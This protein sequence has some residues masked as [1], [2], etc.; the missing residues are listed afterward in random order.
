M[1]DV[2]VAITPNNGIGYNG[3]IPWHCSEDL[4]RFRKMTMGKIL[5]VGRKTYETLPEMDGRICLVLSRNTENPHTFP[6]FTSALEYSKIFKKEVMVIGGASVYAEAFAHPECGKVHVTRIFTD[7]LCDTFIPDITKMGFRK[8]SQVKH[9]QYS[10]EKYEKTDH[11]EY[12]YLDLVRKVLD[13]GQLKMD[14]T[15]V[16]TLSCFGATMR[17]SL[18]DGT[19]PLLTTKRVFFRGIL[20]ELLWFIKGSTDARELSEQGVHIWDGNASR[21]FLDSRGLCYEEGVLGPVYGYQWRSFGGNYPEMDGIDQIVN[22]IH[23]IRNEPNS[24]RMILCAWNPAQQDQM[25]LPPCH[26]LSQFYVSQG[27]LS[28]QMYQRSADIGLGVPFNIASY[29]LLTHMIAHVCGLRAGEFIHVIGDAHI[30]Q[31]HASSLL[32]QLDRKPRPFPTIHFK[33]NR[34]DIDEFEF[35]DFELRN[36][37]PHKAIKLDLAV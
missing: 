15:N 9:A 36:Y 4:R 17:F 14:R 31:N 27:K 22:L 37:Q 13:E 18:K 25:A 26:I 34:Q 10:F 12:Q 33:N 30:Y 1:F 21:E 29:A 2:I 7:V 11:E 16:G 5:I 32:S 19:L 24:R 28:C 3:S 6:S 35:D 8:T 23:L 20:R